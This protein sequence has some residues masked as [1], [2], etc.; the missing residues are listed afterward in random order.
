MGRRQGEEEGGKRKGGKG[1]GKA[2]EEK[3]KG[4]CLDTALAAALIAVR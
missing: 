3:G 2:G 4:F 1:K